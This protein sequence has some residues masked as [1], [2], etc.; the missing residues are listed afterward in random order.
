M[1]GR[2][3][4]IKTLALSK[5]IHLFTA[6]PNP[7]EECLKTLENICFKFIWNNKSEK[8]KRT[9]LCNNYDNGGLKMI[10]IQYFCM[11][12][13]ITWIKMLLDDLNFSD[14]KTLIIS[15]LA[16]YGGNYLWLPRDP[17]PIFKQILNPF[18]KN[19][20][21]PWLTFTSG[22]QQTENPLVKPIFNNNHIKIDN[23]TI[24]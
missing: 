3:C 13:K 7:P 23:K 20:Y 9:T 22:S 21:E 11:A 17:Q 10:N 16:K 6:L 14:W 5:V 1:Y 4:I 18:W 8:I 2:I 19:V 24:F 12:Q 15:D